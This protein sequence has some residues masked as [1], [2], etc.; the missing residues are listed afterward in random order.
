VAAILRAKILAS[1]L[2]PEGTGVLA[3]LAAFT[4]VLVPFA[5]LGAGS[6]VITMIA[7]ARARGDLDRV[8]RITSTARSLITIRTAA[9]STPGRSTTISKVES[10]SNTSSGGEHSPVS[11]RPHCPPSSLKI[12]PSS[13][14]KSASSEGTTMACTRVRIGPSSHSVRDRRQTQSP[15]AEW[16]IGNFNT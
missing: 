7:D 13:A 9:G 6:G 11:G 8:R 12:G 10:V 5:T 4:A 15:W 1:R 3:Q 2:G 16:D 14:R